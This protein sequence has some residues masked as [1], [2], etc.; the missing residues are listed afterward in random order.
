MSKSCQSKCITQQSIFPVVF[1]DVEIIKANT[2][3][4]DLQQKLKFREHDLQILY[5]KSLALK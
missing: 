4:T 2:L 5:K 3:I 1:R